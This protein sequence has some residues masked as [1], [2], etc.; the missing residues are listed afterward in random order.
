MTI[1]INIPNSKMKNSHVSSTGKIIL[2]KNLMTI[3]NKIVAILPNLFNL[4]NYFKKIQY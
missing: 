4:K 3:E 2:D 1:N